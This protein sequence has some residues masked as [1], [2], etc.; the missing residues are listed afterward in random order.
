MFIFCKKAIVIQKTIYRNMKSRHVSTKV[1]IF[2]S[3]IP[4]LGDMGDF[5][6]LTCNSPDTSKVSYS[7][8]AF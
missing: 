1:R 7:S 4:M 8:T 3:P 6:I 2:W 5:P